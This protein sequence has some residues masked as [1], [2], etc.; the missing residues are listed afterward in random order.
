MDD[1][2]YTRLKIDKEFKSL[3]RPLSEAEYLQLEANLIADGCR[4]PIITWKGFIIDGHN[5][6][7]I[8]RKNRL[9]FKTQE[10]HFDSRE[11]VIA[12]ICA[13]QL[14]RRN[15]SEETRKYLIGVQYESEK[16]VNQKRMQLD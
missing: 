9:P 11:E 15:I 16:I 6:Y 7:E 13:N 10:M 1:I 3:I 8:C 5:R 14:G 2:S 4:D 12:W